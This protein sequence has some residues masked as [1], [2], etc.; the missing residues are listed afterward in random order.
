MSD[1]RLTGSIPPELSHITNLGYLELDDNQLTGPIPQELGNLESLVSL[2]LSGNQLSGC[3][4]DRLR[5][6]QENDFD[7]LGLD[8]C[9]AVSVIR[10]R[11]PASVDMGKFD[12]RLEIIDEFW[13]NE[14]KS[15]NRPDDGEYYSRFF[16]FAL[17]EHADVTITLE[18]DEDAY[19]YLLEGE[20][21]VGRDSLRG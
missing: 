10:R 12:S 17:S 1:N 3:I 19:L 15:V 21:R 2:F 16:T 8:F 5:D 18:S 11:H 14:C 6:V 20:G 13:I 9:D 7:E 4:P